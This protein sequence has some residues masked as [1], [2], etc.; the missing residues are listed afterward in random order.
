[1]SKQKVPCGGFYIDNKTLK[2]ED[3]V[4]KAIG[5]EQHSY[6]IAEEQDVL[7]EKVKGFLTLNLVPTDLAQHVAEGTTVEFS[8]EGINYSGEAVIDDEIGWHVISSDGLENFVELIYKIDDNELLIIDQ[9]YAGIEIGKYYIVEAFVLEE[10][11]M[12]STRFDV[13]F[14]PQ[15]GFNNYAINQSFYDIV[16]AFENG[17]T[18][19]ALLLGATGILFF[20]L[21]VMSENSIL[22]SHLEFDTDNSLMIYHYFTLSSDDQLSYNYITYKLEEPIT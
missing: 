10:Y 20:E 3:G 11:P 8:I 1:M 5:E 12:P 16:G 17:N 6:A 14:T 13:I 2:I 19:N 18:I 22:F 21:N 15:A 7:C 4:L 9:N